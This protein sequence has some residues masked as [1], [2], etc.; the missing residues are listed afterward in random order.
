MS[1]SPGLAALGWGAPVGARN[2]P[3]SVA[4]IDTAQ[5]DAGRRAL[6]RA[7]LEFARCA[8]FDSIAQP[9][10]LLFAPIVQRPCH[11]FQLIHCLVANR[12]RNLVFSVHHG[13]Q[14][15]HAAELKTPEGTAFQRHPATFAL[16]PA[17]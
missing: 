4:K 10:E 17:D 12:A 6:E 1:S 8:L 7:G 5:D 11:L 13:E 2:G 16:R 3:G 15:D 14:H 9:E